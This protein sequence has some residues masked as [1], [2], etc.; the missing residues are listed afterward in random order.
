[1]YQHMDGVEYRRLNPKCKVSMYIKYAVWLAILAV[2]LVFAY[3][4]TVGG[5]G[6]LALYICIAL[7]SVAAAYCIVAPIIYYRRYRYILTN[8]KV[9]VRRG[10]IIVRHTLVPIERIHQVEVSS[11]PINNMLGLANVQIT[12]AGGTAFLEYLE[13]DEADR[14]AEELNTHVARI[15]KGRK[16]DV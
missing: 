1:M 5:F 14:V 6:A 4:M 8:D 9:D 13:R 7:F 15:L 10:I 3:F 16:E 11:G 12:T 2:I